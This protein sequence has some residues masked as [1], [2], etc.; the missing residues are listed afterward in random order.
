MSIML[1]YKYDKHLSVYVNYRRVCTDF[2][3]TYKNTQG[4]NRCIFELISVQLKRYHEDYSILKGI[5][6]PCLN[7]SNS[8]TE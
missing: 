1:I 4:Y 2:Q 3:A 6:L 8:N 7:I 5:H